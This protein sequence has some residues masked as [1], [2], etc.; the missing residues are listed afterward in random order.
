MT[1]VNTVVEVWKRCGEFIK[2]FYRYTS[3]VILSDLAHFWLWFI[4]CGFTEANPVNRSITEFKNM[5]MTGVKIWDIRDVKRFILDSGLRFKYDIAD[6]VERGFKVIKNMYGIVRYYYMSNKTDYLSSRV[7]REELTKLL[8]TYRFKIVSVFLSF[9]DFE[10]LPIDTHVLNVLKRHG[11]INV[12]QVT[13]GSQVLSKS[14]YLEIEQLLWNMFKKFGIRLNY[15]DP[16]L[17]IFDYGINCD[18]DK[19]F[20]WCVCKYIHDLLNKWGE[21]VT[22]IVE[23][24]NSARFVS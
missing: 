8:K 22:S 20:E 5:L 24:L 23:Y 21:V 16:I 14:R 11:L 6:R 18:I 10:V 1:F 2:T 13:K 3:N 12:V 9:M 4:Y 15:L 7:L 19:S 17:F